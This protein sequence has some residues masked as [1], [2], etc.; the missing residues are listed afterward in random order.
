M[1]VE[2]WLIK[3][4]ILINNCITFLLIKFGNMH[5]NVNSQFIHKKNNIN[6]V[7]L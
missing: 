7:I 4:T 5:I 1:T 2:R 6:I 3:L